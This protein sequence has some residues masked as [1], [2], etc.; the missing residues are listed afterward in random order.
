[1]L[2]AGL[3]LSRQRLDVHVLDEEGRTVE[4][5]AVRPDADALQHPLAPLAAKTDKIDAWVLAELGRREL[6][7]AIWL[8][9]PANR[10]ERASG[11][12]S[13]SIWCATG[14]LSSRPH[15]GW[16]G[17]VW[18]SPGI[19]CQ[20]AGLTV[21][22]ETSSVRPAPPMSVGKVERETVSEFTT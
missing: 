18:P 12:G 1:M 5:T 19:D 4:A 22:R 14:P 11:R 8:P 7:P 9:D 13:D 10:A 3:D 15:A 2:F 17:G 6:V 21:I 20:S 16:V